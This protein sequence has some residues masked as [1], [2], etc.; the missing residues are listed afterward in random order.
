MEYSRDINV[1]ERHSVSNTT[2]FSY[3]S[4]K[5]YIWPTIARLNLKGTTEL[6]NRAHSTED[7]IAEVSY[8]YI[9][10]AAVR[11]AAVRIAAVRIKKIGLSYSGNPGGNRH[12]SS[13]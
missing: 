13:H 4:F 7:I 5:K 2:S 9:C 1:K 10:I 8:M 11:I 12:G 3:L 6:Q